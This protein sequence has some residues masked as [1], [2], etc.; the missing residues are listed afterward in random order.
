MKTNWLWDTKLDEG[1]ARAILSNERNP[2]FFIYLTRLLSRVRDPETAFTYIDRDIFSRHWPSIRERMKKDAW[3][4][5]AVD[6]WQKVFARVQDSPARSSTAS[7]IRPAI[8]FE[9]LSVAEQIRTARMASGLSQL[10]LARQMGV[11][12]Q[13]VSSLECGRENVTVDTLSKVA[14]TLHKKVVIQ[15]V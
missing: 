10:Q 1:Q 15:F 14:A 3:A 4:R 2:R 7:G 12:Q 13:Y 5:P 9:R 11:I 8:P 6:R